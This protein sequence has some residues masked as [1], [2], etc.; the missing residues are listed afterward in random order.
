MSE[1]QLEELALCIEELALC[2]EA[3]CIAGERRVHRVVD[4]HTSQKEEV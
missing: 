2:I 3:R 1:M 4:V